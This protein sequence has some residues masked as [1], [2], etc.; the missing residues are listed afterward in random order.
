MRRWPFSFALGCWASWN[1]QEQRD[2][3]DVAICYINL[4][5]W[6]CAIDLPPTYVLTP[7]SVTWNV[8]CFLVDEIFPPRST[9]LKPIHRPNSGGEETY[10]KRLVA[11]RKDIE[12]YVGVLQAR[13]RILRHYS[14]LLNLTDIVPAVQRA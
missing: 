4:L 8:L 14:T 7:N 5:G 12:W 6:W 13:V 9:C 2:G 10:S 11:I 1:Q 3:Y